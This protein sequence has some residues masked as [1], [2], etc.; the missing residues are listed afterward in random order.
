MV[1]RFLQPGTTMAASTKPNRAAPRADAS[2]WQGDASPR[3]P[4]VSE[5]QAKHGQAI[6]PSQAL[7]QGLRC[8]VLI[9]CY[10]EEATVA[11]V[12]A[13]FRARM[14]WAEI[15]VYDNNSSDATALLAAAA[16]ARVGR[17]SRQG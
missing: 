2:R 1:T 8:A 5:D 6:L 12:V 13:D 9:P 16:G 10:N 17:E 7:F 4:R 11:G 14:P 3:K 15:H